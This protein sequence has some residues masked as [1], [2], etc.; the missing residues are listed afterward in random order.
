MEE[1]TS[2]YHGSN[3]QRDQ[4]SE[5]SCSIHQISKTIL[6]SPMV[7]ELRNFEEF[8]R[9]KTPIMQ[10]LFVDAI[11]TQEIRFPTAPVAE[12]SE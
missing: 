12:V 10:A 8:N 3:Q 2:I 1:A 6:S 5:L 7:F 11:S 4:Y 9:L